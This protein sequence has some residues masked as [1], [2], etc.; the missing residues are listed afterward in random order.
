MC[1][2]A[3]M[4]VRADTTPVD[5][6]LRVAQELSRKRLLGVVLNRVPAVNKYH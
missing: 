3:L 2:A 6:A 5:S 1:D 4:V